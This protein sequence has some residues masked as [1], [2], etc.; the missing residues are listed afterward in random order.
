MTRSAAER[1]AATATSRGAQS[2]QER[3]ADFVMRN[4]NRSS[5]GFQGSTAPI[6]QVAFRHLRGAGPMKGGGCAT[7][8]YLKRAK[9]VSFFC[10]RPGA[11]SGGADCALGEH[12]TVLLECTHLYGAVST[13]PIADAQL[14]AKQSRLASAT[15][16]PWFHRRSVPMRGAEA[17]QVSSV[18]GFF[19][20]A[21]LGCH[22]QTA[23][24]CSAAKA[25]DRQGQFVGKVGAVQPAGWQAGI[26]LGHSLQSLRHVE[27]RLYS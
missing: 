1:P 13:G 23:S 27:V 22:F 10:R 4:W 17:R 9:P 24:C 21:T 5:P 18:K 16:G 11:T 14:S 20:V 26:H 3:R 15:G 8:G 6:W 19:W 12:T 7:G 2:A 25:P